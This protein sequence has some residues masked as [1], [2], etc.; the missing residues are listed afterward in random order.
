MNLDDLR[1]Q[2]EALQD[3]QGRLTPRMVVEAARPKNHPLHAAVFDRGVREAAEEYYLD[4]AR[5]LIRKV[6]L[7]FVRADQTLGSVPRW[8]SL[9]TAE[10]PARAYQPVEVV[11]DDPLLRA[12]LLR[13]AERDWRTLR[14]RYEHLVEFF[15]IVRRDLGSEEAA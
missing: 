3:E 15:E 10:S 5:G 4:R 7:P 14:A 9:S 8:V 2:L 1:T 12:M 13:D 6:R 11:A